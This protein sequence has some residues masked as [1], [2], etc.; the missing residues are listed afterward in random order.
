MLPLGG[1]SIPA[2]ERDLHVT[3]KS[4]YGGFFES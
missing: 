3:P 1:D 2:K 4:G